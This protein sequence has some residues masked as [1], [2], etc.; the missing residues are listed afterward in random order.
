M[1]LIK[2]P[3]RYEQS[4]KTISPLMSRK[5]VMKHFG[6][7]STTLHRWTREKGLL[8]SFFIEGRKFFKTVDVENLI[9]EQYS[10]Y[11]S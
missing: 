4:K 9:E 2:F 1:D 8:K 5:D 10:T 7:G 6:I 3:K 11:N